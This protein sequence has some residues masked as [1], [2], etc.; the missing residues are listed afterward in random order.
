M[1]KFI[2]GKKQP[3]LNQ[4]S[5]GN[6]LPKSMFMILVCSCILLLCDRIAAQDRVRKFKI[7]STSMWPALK[8]GQTVLID[9]N[10]DKIGRGDIV[11]YRFP[12][13]PS[14]SFVKRV[15]GLP[16]ER[17]DI[18]EQGKITINGQVIEEPYVLPE[19][20][21]DAIIRWQRIEKGWKDI[22]EGSYFVM[23]DSRDASNDSR[24]WGPVAKEYI[25]AK[26]I[27]R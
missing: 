1:S 4:V 18:D 13:N 21:E 19:R 16:G 8:K 26:V 25:W 17:I 10:I 6:W 14:V 2:T 7:E 20:N 22:K 11:V 5:H 9:T 27:P 24:T 23:G 12:L 15:I 3:K